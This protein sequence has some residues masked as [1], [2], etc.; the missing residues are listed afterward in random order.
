MGKG[1]LPRKQK[2]NWIARQPK[3]TAINSLLAA[4]AFYYDEDVQVQWLK[5]WDE[6]FLSDDAYYPVT[7]SIGFMDGE[8]W[9]QGQE[10]LTY[11]C[12]VSQEFF[13][14]RGFELGDT[15]SVRLIVRVRSFEI[16]IQ[17]ELR[18]V[19]PIPPAVRKA[20]MY[21]YPFGRIPGS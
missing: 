21:P 7:D 9:R 14:A 20:F 11:P 5:G 12:I 19:E 16:E 13:K 2:I 18:I 1:D 10:P 15:F 3:L 8:T 6:S 4:P 17:P